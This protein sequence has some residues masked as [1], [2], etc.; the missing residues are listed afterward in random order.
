VRRFV[1]LLA[2]ALAGRAW[3]DG[4]LVRLSQ[5]S[6]PFTITVF[7]APTPLRA[8]PIDL[9]LLVQ[10]AAA[11]TPV[12]DATVSVTL[13]AADDPNR[14]LTAVA[15]HG[16]A[17]N[18]LLYAALLRVPAAGRW[19]VE[20]TVNAETV[21]FEMD[22]A[23]ALPDAIAFWPYLALPFAGLTIFA[24]HQWLVLRRIDHQDTKRPGRID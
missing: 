2:I 11:G 4:G 18:K 7:S 19:L 9:S 15:T 21:R 10:R 5:T 20:A 23:P 6:G 12:L 22:A 16:Q 17:T 1:A 24:L 3:A 14:V 8:G 13:R